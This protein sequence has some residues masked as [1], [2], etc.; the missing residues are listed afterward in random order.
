MTWKLFYIFQYKDNVWGI[1]KDAFWSM[2]YSD[3]KDIPAL[4]NVHWTCV[5][6]DDSGDAGNGIDGG[7]DT[8]DDNDDDDDEYGDDNDDYDD[9]DNN[10]DETDGDIMTLV[11]MIAS[12]CNN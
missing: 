6:D 10:D 5:G 7:G 3:T 1:K 8:G 9:D 11:M 4:D 2:H 12:H